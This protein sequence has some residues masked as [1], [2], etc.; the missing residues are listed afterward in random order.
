MRLCRLAFAMLFMMIWLATDFGDAAAKAP[1][2]SDRYSPLNHKRPIRPETC[3]IILHTTEGELEGSLRKIQRYGEAHYFVTPSGEIYRIIDRKKIAT[4]TGRSMW[5]GRS[6]L[7]NFSL[8]IEVVGYHDRDITGAQYTS[9]RELLRQLKNLYRIRDNNVLTHSMVAYG[10][11]NPFHSKMHRGRKRCGMIFAHP[12]VRKRLGLSP[13]TVRDSDVE[14]GRLV[15]ADPELHSFLYQS[16][17]VLMASAADATGRQMLS[18]EPSGD[19]MVI[20]KGV[21]AWR[22]ARE[23]YDAPG[24]VYVYP[25]GKRLRGNEIR[26]WGSI[27]EG[28]RVLFMDG[29]Q[30][31]EQEFEGFLEI[32][33]DGSAA[34]DLAGDLYAAATTIY[35]FPD[36][37]IRTGAELNRTA[38]LRRLLNS[39]PKGTRILLG[40]VYG[41]YVQK[42]RSASRIA[43][44]KWKYPSTFYRLPD[45]RILSGDEMDDKA[46]PVRTLIFMLR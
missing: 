5:E 32:G 29:V 7:D 10:L 38:S 27:P 30:E 1:K 28:T 22:I 42:E 6:T 19:S 36:G 45:G 37:L 31:R 40:Y 46:I 18:G 12:D 15:V 16:P 23:K 21:N 2:I 11:P 43:G 34:H 13:L 20:S 17:A 33:K 25:D 14:T 9:L 39:P 24:T 4:H 8:G 41:G 3:Y 26:E 35:F 44:K